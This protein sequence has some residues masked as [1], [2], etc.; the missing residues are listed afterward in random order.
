MSD[1][2]HLQVEL[3]LLR[4]GHGLD[5]GVHRGDYVPEGELLQIEHHLAALNLGDVQDIVDEA[6]EV[7]SGGHDLPG[8]LPHLVR[9]VGVL[10]Q[11]GGEAQHGVHGGADVVGHIGQEG[12]FGLAGDLGGPERLGQLL[13]VELPLRLLLPAQLFLLSPVDVVQ[14]DAQEEGRQQRAHHNHDMLVDR[15]PLLLDGLHRHIAHQENPPAVHRPHV[16]EGV[17][18]PDVVVEQQVPSGA[19]AVLHLL[20]DLRVL[21][22]V[23]PVKVVQVQVSRAALAH[24]LGLEDKALALC[25]H[26]VQGRLL[27]VKPVGEGLVDG[28]VDIFG[29]EGPD[30]L[31]LPHHRALDGIGPGA[32]I[33]QVGL[34]DLHPHHRAAGGEVQLLPGEDLPRV[35]DPLR[36]PREDEGDLDHGLVPL[37]DLDVRL[38]VLRPGDLLGNEL[39]ELRLAA[40]DS[41]NGALNQVQALAQVLDGGGGHFPGYFLGDRKHNAPKHAE[42]QNNRKQQRKFSALFIRHSFHSQSPFPRLSSALSIKKIPAVQAPAAIL[43]FCSIILFCSARC[44]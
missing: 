32:H 17:D 5:D 37:I 18:L 31:L 40:Q 29:I 23:R 11:E 4:L 26:D 44:Q 14:A 2:G 19:Q 43:P 30:D 6:E 15:P 7:L 9:I 3:L 36:L 1:A 25:V 10:G 24:P 35:G 27:V 13:A 8:I 33:V 41:L 22:V 39:L 28:V 38:R 20:P 34:G 42:N 21:D 16:V 12:G